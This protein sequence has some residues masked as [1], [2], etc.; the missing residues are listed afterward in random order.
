MDVTNSKSPSG[1]DPAKHSVVAFH[2]ITALTDGGKLKDSLG[3]GFKKGRGK[4][5]TPDLGNHAGGPRIPKLIKISQSH[6]NKFKASSGPRIMLK[7]SM[8]HLAMAIKS[9]NPSILRVN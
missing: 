9:P 4:K 6:K 2:E 5:I 7:D 3:D 8:V 1:L